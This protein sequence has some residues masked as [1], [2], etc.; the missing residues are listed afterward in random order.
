MVIFESRLI[1]VKHAERGKPV[2][3]VR[4]DGQCMHANDLI[5]TMTNFFYT[6]SHL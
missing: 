2:A 6:Y 4:L 3:Y 5:I 1:I